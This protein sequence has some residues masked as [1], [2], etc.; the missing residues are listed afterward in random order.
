MIPTESWFIPTNALRIV[1]SSLAIILAILFLFIIILDKT[2]HTVSMMFVANSCLSAFIV[3]CVTFGMS[4]FTLQNDLKQIEYQDS[5]CTIRAYLG[6]ASYCAL[7]YSFLLQALYRYILAVYPTRLSWQSAR[8][9]A[10]AISITWIFAFSYCVP[11]LLTGA[12]IYNVDNQ[13]CQNPLSLSFFQIYGA[14][15]AYVIPISLIIIIYLKLVRYVKKIAKNVTTCNTL[16][17]AEREL[18]MVRRTMVL[19]TILI[20][21]FFP[22]T[23]IWFMGFFGK[24]P[25]YHF[26]I[27]YIFVDGSVLSVMISLFQFTHPLKA[28]IMK[29]IKRRINVVATIRT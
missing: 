24:A 18:K 9:Q 14:F 19:I 20:T 2:C 8:I 3:G 15:C 12:I 6:Y 11:L 28:S 5:F 26:R 27:A 21:I 13:I 23:I 1:C 29:R 22:Y 7:N 25:K 10:I 4:L 16:A 17:R